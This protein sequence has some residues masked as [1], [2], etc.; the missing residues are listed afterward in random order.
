MR[1]MKATVGKL[2][3]FTTVLF[4]MASYSFITA[5]GGDHFEVYVNKKLVFQQIVSQPSGIKSVE[6]D[7]SNIND[8]V[9]V[10]YSHCGK[11]GTKRSIVI[12]DGNSVLK[13]WKF[14]DV[15]SN[16]SEKKFMSMNARDI[17][18]FKSKGSDRKLKLYYS[19]DEMPDGKLLASI[20]L[21]TENRKVEP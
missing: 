8:Q 16:T 6:L 17:L 1:I 5:P 7:H 9:D 20:I 3:L 14:A 10:F 15:A 18:A 11:I 13:Q 4:T 2:A 19:S 12:K 21:D